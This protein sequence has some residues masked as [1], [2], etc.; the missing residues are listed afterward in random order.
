MSR[1]HSAYYMLV[2]GGLAED[3]IKQVSGFAD[4]RLQ[5]PADPLAAAN[6]RIEILIEADE[7]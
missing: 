5:V 2:H 7:G 3:R 1:A 4:R 6:R